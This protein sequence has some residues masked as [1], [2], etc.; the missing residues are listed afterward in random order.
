MR[1]AEVR[2]AKEPDKEECAI[3]NAS[4]H[5]ID[6]TSSAI[7]RFWH[8]RH[9]DRECSSEVSGDEHIHFDLQTD[10]HPTRH[11]VFELE[12][13]HEARYPDV[14]PLVLHSECTMCFLSL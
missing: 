8:F 13:S 11:S 1:V 7:D 9:P 10:V 12:M 6:D 3:A 4:A 2:Y 5:S 14:A